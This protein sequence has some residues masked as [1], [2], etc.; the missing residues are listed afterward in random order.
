MSAKNLIQKF[1][2]L[3]YL[4]VEI[5]LV[6]GELRDLGIKDEIYPFWDP[7]LD[8]NILRGYIKHD[9]YT[10]PDGTSRR[11]AEI[12]YAKMGHEWERL[13]GCKELLHLLDPEGQRV[14][15][16]EDVERLVEKIIL[17][18]DLVDPVK[19]GPH[20]LI[21]RVAITYAV[22]TLFPFDARQVLM[23]AYTA[24]KLTLADIEVMAELPRRYVALVMSDEWDLIHRIITG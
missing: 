17:P 24:K 14:W 13:V 7:N 16:P 1:S 5:D 4:P 6:I 22:A 18:P 8:P 12:T 9:E 23:P 21:D 11:V 15:Q 10:L 3:D 2:K 20:A 19:D